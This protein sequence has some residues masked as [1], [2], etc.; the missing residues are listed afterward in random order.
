MRIV[1]WAPFAPWRC[2]LYEAARD[3]ARADALRGHDVLFCDTG[4]IGQ[5]GGAREFAPVGT[6]DA[7]GGW[8]IQVSDWPAAL[9][10]DLWICHDGINDNIT[11]RC[12][13]PMIWAVHAR[14]LSAFRT[15]QEH[16]PG[17]PYSIIQ[18]LATWPRVK[19]IVTMWEE[20]VPHW[21]VVVPPEKLFCTGEPPID[22]DR[23]S[24]EGPKYP[25]APDK[26]GEINVLICD[27][28][29]NDMDV[30]EVAVGCL[31]AARRQAGMRI[32]FWAVE[33]DKQG[34]WQ[35][36]WRAMDVAGCL[37]EIHEREQNIADVYRA[38]DFLVSP[39]AIAVRTIAEALACGLPVVAADGCRYTRYQM[40][41]GDPEDV[42]EIVLLAAK[43]AQENGPAQR[44][45]ARTMS[46]AFDLAHFGAKLEPIYQEAINGASKG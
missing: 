20:F 13:I 23:Y 8:P 44:E 39:H 6:A 32:H 26:R 27:T 40:R 2:G 4:A 7:R 34:P 31:E 12:Q 16:L 41:P 33:K 1:H 15:E 43:D 22:R 21:S 29:R 25:I 3:W 35:H 42:A 38:T 5:Q 46:A 14:P 18:E 19:R 37:G 30:Y 36:V 9:N 10:A 17:R 28:W 24:P 11:A 45:R